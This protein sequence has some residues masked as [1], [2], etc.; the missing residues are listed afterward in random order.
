MSRD[1]TS[2]R[3]GADARKS[4]S[5]HG[6]EGR[7]RALEDEFFHAQNEELIRA[8][9]ERSQHDKEVNR[10]AEEC[11]IQ[12][13]RI[14]DALVDQGIRSETLPALALTPLI[15]VAWADDQISAWESW[16][17]VEQAQE[18]NIASDSDPYALMA[19]WMKTKPSKELFEAWVLYAQEIVSRLPDWERHHFVNH[20]LD[21]ARVVARA[22]RAGALK[23]L[24][25]EEERNIL[26]RIETALNQGSEGGA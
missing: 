5:A 17:I 10:L 18:L 8:L 19:A 6:L 13:R 12:N 24:I 4:Q 2:A 25:S 7:R 1:L 3:A 21:S 14:L 9:R 20:I 11:G 16:E 23:P 22:S 15:A 26:T